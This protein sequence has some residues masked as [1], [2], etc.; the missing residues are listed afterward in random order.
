MRQL[1]LLISTVGYLG[2]V[3]VAPG[4]VG[5]LIGLALFFFLQGTESTVVELGTI[6]ALFVVGVWSSTVAEKYFNRVDPAPVVIDETVGML[7][8]LAF[9]PVNFLGAF[10]GFLIFRVLDVT[11]PFPVARLERLPRGLGVMADDGMAA[12]YGNLI[13]RG[14]LA[15]APNWLS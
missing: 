5:S 14:L 8:T 12:V 9:L 7:I 4:T 1:A 10:V 6:V 2:Y 3:P 13:M 15:V 11:K